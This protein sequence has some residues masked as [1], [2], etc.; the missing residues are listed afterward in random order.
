[1]EIAR[2][3][4]AEDLKK[5]EPAIKQGEDAIF[6]AVL[7]AIS[8][9]FTDLNKEDSQVEF[10]GATVKYSHYMANTITDAILAKPS[11]RLI[12]PFEIKTA[13]SNG[14]RNV[15]GDYFGFNV[16]NV[17]LFLEQ[18]MA[19]PEHL[20]IVDAYHAAVKRIGQEQQLDAHKPL[21]DQE[22]KK[23]IETYLPLLQAEIEKI[24]NKPNVKPAVVRNEGTDIAQE[25]MRDFDRLFMENPVGKGGRFIE[26]EGVKM[27]IEEYL[28]YRFN[29]EEFKK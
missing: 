26:V 1:M 21:T 23:N 6:K 10:N 13:I 14:L 8:T 3:T 17:E 20:A 18:Y 24:T 12:R 25:W 9:A 28:Q 16:V 27:N 7:A 22:K 4:H 15:Y 11:L 29:L 19:S 5:F 2:I